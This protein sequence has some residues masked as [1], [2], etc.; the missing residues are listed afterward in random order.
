MIHTNLFLN[1]KSQAVRFHKS[2][3]FPPEVHE[4]T[5]MAVGNTRIIAP[6]GNTWDAWFAQPTDDDALLPERDQPAM[7]ERE[8]LA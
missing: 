6:A 5:I 8:T 3:A 1:N 7:Q 4:V 2:V